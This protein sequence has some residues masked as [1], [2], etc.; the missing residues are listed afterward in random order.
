MNKRKPFNAFVVWVKSLFT[1]LNSSFVFTKFLTVVFKS[2]EVAVQFNNNYLMEFSSY[3]LKLLLNLLVHS[4]FISPNFITAAAKSNFT[5]LSS[6]LVVFKSSAVAA[7]K[8]K[9]FVTLIKYFVNPQIG[10]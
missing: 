6:P 2:S 8:L 1:R 9:L 10:F 3:K 5:L 7:I 4:L